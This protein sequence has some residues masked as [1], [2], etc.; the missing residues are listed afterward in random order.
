M[1]GL[2]QYRRLSD[3]FKN[4]LDWRYLKNNW[5][6]IQNLTLVTET[7]HSQY[8]MNIVLCMDRESSMYVFN[9]QQLTYSA[10]IFPV[11]HTLPFVDRACRRKPENMTDGESRVCLYFRLICGFYLAVCIYDDGYIT[12]FQCSG[13]VAFLFHPAFRGM[14]G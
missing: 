12:L 8:V 10:R 3:G 6:E 5:F 7:Q 14:K 9:P 13:F 4:K 2:I 1:L 11:G